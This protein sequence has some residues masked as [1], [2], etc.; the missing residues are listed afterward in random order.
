MQNDAYL[1]YQSFP[2]Y[3]TFKKEVL[4]LVPSRFE[5]GP[6]YSANPRDRKTLRKAAFRPIEK[7]LVFDIDLTDYD[8]V[9]LCCQKTETCV[10]CWNLITLAIRIIDEI[11]RADFGY[12]HILWV[13]SGRRG[14][15]AWVCDEKARQLSDSERRAIASYMEIVKSKKVDLKR[16]LHPLVSWA[17]PHCIIS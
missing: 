4:R 17:D 1:R 6:I 10:K 16:P 15:H 5:I 13:Y 3:E 2:N 8:N 7:E 11:L 9:R 14:A 12:R